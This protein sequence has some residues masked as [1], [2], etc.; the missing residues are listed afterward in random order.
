MKKRAIFL[1]LVVLGRQCVAEAV[2]EFVNH[3]VGEEGHVN[4]CRIV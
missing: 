1:V 3:T 4:S 2:K